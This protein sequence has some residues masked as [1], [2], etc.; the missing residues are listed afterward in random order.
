MTPIEDYLGESWLS[1]AKRH[2]AND[3]G[4]AVLVAAKLVRDFALAGLALALLWVT[5]TLFAFI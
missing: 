5:A 3:R 1:F 4:L 2:R